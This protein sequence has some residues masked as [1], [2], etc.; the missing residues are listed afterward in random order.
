MHN[1]VIEAVGALMSRVAPK[2]VFAC[3][4]RL[5]FAAG[6]LF[7]VAYGTLQ[8]VRGTTQSVFGSQKVQST[9]IKLC[10]DAAY[11]QSSAGSGSAKPPAASEIVEACF[12]YMEE[13]DEPTG[14]VAD[15]IGVLNAEVLHRTVLVA[16]LRGD[17]AL[18]PERYLAFPGTHIKLSYLQYPE[19]CDASGC[20]A[21]AELSQNQLQQMKTAKAM[22]MSFGNGLHGGS[23]ITPRACCRFAEAFAGAPVPDGAHDHAQREI[24][25]VLVH[26]FH[27]FIQ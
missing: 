5:L 23:I 10:F 8:P 13:R 17:E 4:I 3:S 15:V 14:M 25:E 16:F 18:S 12:T 20:Y 2:R 6:A 9:W 27:D 11:G 19:T 7:M 1:G 24:V 21:R 26:K 22:T